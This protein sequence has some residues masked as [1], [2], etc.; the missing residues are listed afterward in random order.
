MVI[1]IAVRNYNDHMMPQHSRDGEAELVSLIDFI[2]AA[3]PAEPVEWQGWEIGPVPGGRNNLL[4]RALREG[5]DLAV[6]ITRRDARDR[7]GRE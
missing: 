2:M 4:Y 6:K 1:I 7:A 5:R 3:R